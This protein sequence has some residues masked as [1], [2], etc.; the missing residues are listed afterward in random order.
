HLD[1]ERISETR[2]MIETWAVQKAAAAAPRAEVLTQLDGLLRIMDDDRTDA[3]EFHTADAEFHS[4]LTESAENE[5]V[6]LVFNGCR[7]I[8]QRIMYDAITRAGEWSQVR[9][10]LYEEH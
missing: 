8:I 4:T 1:V 6:S 7:D 10:G 9:R 5:L 2:V 3:E